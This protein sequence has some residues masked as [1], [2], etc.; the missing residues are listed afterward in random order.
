MRSREREA[1][2]DF[3]EHFIALARSVYRCNDQRAALKRKIMPP[4]ALAW[5][6]KR[7]T[8]VTESI[9]RILFIRILHQKH[10]VVDLLI[11]RCHNNKT[12]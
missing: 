11:S 9:S 12:A 4:P 2:S 5:W 7:A 8:G 1:A 3:G 10:L 6:K